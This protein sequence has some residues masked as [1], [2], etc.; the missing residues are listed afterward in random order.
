MV[1]ECGTEILVSRNG[2][3]TKVVDD[4]NLQQSAGCTGVNGSCP[5][6]YCCLFPPC[7]S[8]L[9]RVEH[10]DGTFVHYRHMGPND[11]FVQEGQLVRRGQLLGLVGTTGNST[12]PHLHIATGSQMFFEA[13][14]PNAPMTILECYEPTP[15]NGPACWSPFT[16]LR[17]NNVKI[18]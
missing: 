10:Q 8:N 15:P 13:V 14:S 1:A 12:E 17:S 6:T 7:G 18:P 11:V 16:D 5:G 2:R 9:V 4:Q 3:V